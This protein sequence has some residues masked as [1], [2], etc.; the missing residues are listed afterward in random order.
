MVKVILLIAL[1]L[2]TGSVIYKNSSLDSTNFDPESS[3]L[4]ADESNSESALIPVAVMEETTEYSQYLFNV[5]IASTQQDRV[6]G[7]SNRDSLPMDQGL[8]FIFEEPEI[9]GIWMKDM[10]F[11]I[12]IIWLDQAK[13]I[14]DIEP[15]VS[16]DTFPTVFKPFDPALY[17]IEVNAGA[18]EDLGIEVGD[19]LDW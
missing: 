5:T 16:P 4:I 1:T 6:L 12:D 11:P 13:E 7:L 19:K 10:N 15:N 17:V 18:V 9:A 8:L 14:I 3:Q 2:G